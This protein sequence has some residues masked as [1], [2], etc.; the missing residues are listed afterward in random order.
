M[1][2]G[3]I[4]WLLIDG[5]S[6]LHRD[7]TC[8]ALLARDLGLAR[9]LLV[10]RVEGIAACWATRVTV[11]FDGRGR[12]GAGTDEPLQTPLEIYFAPTQLTADTV[13]ERW[14][15]AALQPDRIMVI[16]S[17]HA[18]IQTI[19]AAGANYM[20]CDDFLAR[21]PRHGVTRPSKRDSGPQLGDF[22]P[23]NPA[24]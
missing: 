5:Y 20:D 1:K 12:G 2:Q 3:G 19:M 15:C 17:D 11:V 7:P 18:E 23:L 13:I 21:A 14:V 24:K 16:T 22:F 9:Q 8:K 10:R 6:L 4:D